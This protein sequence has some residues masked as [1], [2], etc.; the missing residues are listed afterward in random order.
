MIKVKLSEKTPTILALD[1]EVLEIFFDEGGSRRIHVAHMKS[2]QLDSS[3]DGKR[4]LTVAQKY[5]PILLWVDEEAVAK[6][7]ELIAELRKAM[8]SFQM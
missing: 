1:G 5:D 3:K 7:N 6:V 4:L 2:I 8:T